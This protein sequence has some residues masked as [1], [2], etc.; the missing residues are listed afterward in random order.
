MR[1]QT[2]QASRFE[3]EHDG[4]FPAGPLRILWRT[5]WQRKKGFFESLLDFSSLRNR[6]IREALL[7]PSPAFWIGRCNLDGVHRFFSLLF[8][9]VGYFLWILYVRVRPEFPVTAFRTADNIARAS[10]VRES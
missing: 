2:S 6:K 4:T 8:A 9:V 5:R 10:G 7:P 1:D 3:S